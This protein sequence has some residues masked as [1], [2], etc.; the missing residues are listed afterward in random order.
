LIFLKKK[1]EKWGE[2]KRSAQVLAKASGRTRHHSLIFLLILTSYL[3][4]LTFIISQPA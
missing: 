2:S 1:I 4:T 3:L